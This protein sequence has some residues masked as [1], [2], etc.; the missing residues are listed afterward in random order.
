MNTELDRVLN[1][2]QKCLALSKSAEPHEAAAAM[3]Q[4]QKLMDKYNIDNSTVELAE[5]GELLIKSRVSVSRVKPWESSLMHMLA[6][7][8]GC[9]VLWAASNSYRADVFG[10]WRLIGLK[11]QLKLAEYTA[12]VLIRQLIK[13]RNDYVRSLP[14]YLPRLAK[15]AQGDGFASGY[16]GAVRETVYAFSGYEELEPKLDNY[17]AK[18]FGELGKAKSQSRGV[19]ASGLAAGRAAGS[20]VSLYHGVDGEAQRRLSGG[21]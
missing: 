13:Q 7:A 2:I 20:E 16:V 21:S 17:L 12:E 11:T 9:K 5:I 19:G 10:T 14:D 4:A 3:R 15:A 18:T 1:K 8:Y 6:K